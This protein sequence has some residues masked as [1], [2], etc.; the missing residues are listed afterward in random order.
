MGLQ[1]KKL[2][3]WKIENTQEVTLKNPYNDRLSTLTTNYLG[4]LLEIANKELKLGIT[5]SRFFE[6]NPIWQ[7]Q[8]EKNY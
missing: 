1:V 2:K 4:N 6:I 8:S 3:A 5:E 7:Y